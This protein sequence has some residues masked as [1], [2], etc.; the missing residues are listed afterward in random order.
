MVLLLHIISIALLWQH[1]LMQSFFLIKE[2]AHVMLIDPDSMELFE[3]VSD[4]LILSKMINLAVP[5]IIDE[6]ALNKK[7]KVQV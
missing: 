7:P 6:R 1:I 2:L 4:G 3:K 5:D